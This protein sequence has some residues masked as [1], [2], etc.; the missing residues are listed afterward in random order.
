M[1]N[2]VDTQSM[3]KN[4]P[5]L[6][7]TPYYKND[8]DSGCI[9]S[10]GQRLIAA[11]VRGRSHAHVGTP[12]DDDFF[13]HT[14]SGWSIIAIADGAGSCKYSRQG[15]KIAVSAATG[16]ICDKLD[17]HSQTL[18]DNYPRSSDEKSDK[19]KLINLQNV[20]Y[21]ILV[22]SAFEA[23]KAI[24]KEATDNQ[25]LF[26]DFST[27]LLLAAHKQ[28]AFGHMIIS[29]WVGDGAIAVYQEDGELMLMGEP[30]GGEY[31]GQTR[32]LDKR[33]FA[34]PQTAM[35]RIGIKVV[36]DFSAL[37]LAT[38]GITDPNFESDAEL[39]Q[40]EIWDVLWKNTRWPDSEKNLKEIV[41]TTECEKAKQYLMEWSSFFSPGNHDDRTIGVLTTIKGDGN[42]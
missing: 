8:Q 13:I 16:A 34:D 1:A 29:F 5:T 30:D 24:E 31:A 37:I 35:K 32:F 21:A 11:S 12:R 18:V 33:I 28:T 40:K 38:D 3:W 42:E 23:C 4:I 39:N 41:T 17:V 20:L 25:S 15:S 36:D 19:T 9:E 22:D 14:H 6:T 2:K 10:D 7:K 26:K 27:T